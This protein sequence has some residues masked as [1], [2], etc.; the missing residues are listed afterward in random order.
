M[1][2]GKTKLN[3]QWLAMQNTLS[4]NNCY[5]GNYFSKIREKCTLMFSPVYAILEYSYSFYLIRWSRNLGYHVKDICVGLKIHLQWCYIV[6]F[7]DKKGE[8]M[9]SKSISWSSWLPF[10]NLPLTSSRRYL[11]YISFT[12][13]ENLQTR[14]FSENQASQKHLIL[15]D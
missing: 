14:I 8:A 13:G 5:L 2:G 4:N 10:Y 1:A 9:W 3:V 6:L 11:H 12:M 7:T 15:M